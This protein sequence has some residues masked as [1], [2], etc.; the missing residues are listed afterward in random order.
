MGQGCN[1]PMNLRVEAPLTKEVPGVQG[2]VRTTTPRVISIDIFR[3][4]TMAVMIFVNALSEVR[5]LPW[6]TYHAHASDDVMTYVDMVFPFFLFAVGMSL[7]LA[8]AQRLKRNSSLP[9]LVAHVA[10]RV[11]GLIVLGEILANAQK[12]DPA[13]M[14]MSGS[15]WA[16]LALICAALYLNVYGESKRARTY[17]RVLRAVGLAGVILLLVLFRRTTAG[18]HQA[19]LDFSYPEILGLIGYSYLAVAILY[20]PTRRW[21]CAPPIWFILLVSLCALS[22]AKIVTFPDQVPLYLWPFGNG[23]MCCIIMAGVVTSQI[24]LRPD[25][26]VAPNRA[27]PLA[28]GFSIVTLIA[29]RVLTPLGISKI[30]ATPTWSLY[31]I[32]ASMLLFTLLYWVCDLKQWQRWAVIVRPAGSNTLLTYLLPDL[33]YF[34]L[35]AIGFKYLDVHFN[36]GWSGVVKTLIFTLFMLAAADVLTKARIRLQF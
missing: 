8:V 30:R 18:G 7:P 11:L 33:W 12:A 23:A 6:W 5:G 24:F 28:V 13:R 27:I 29:G 2:T 34:I 21:L 3:G 10:V 15:T 35:S 9:S 36:V 32:A 17:S 19:W 14:G 25:G 4:L 26:R 31:S 16:L 22:T 20:I 1:L